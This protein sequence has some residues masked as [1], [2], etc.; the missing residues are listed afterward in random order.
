MGNVDL[1]HVW[2]ATVRGGRG[3]HSVDDLEVNFMEMESE[4]WGKRYK[5]I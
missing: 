3:L 2:V 4:R 1:P 5:Y